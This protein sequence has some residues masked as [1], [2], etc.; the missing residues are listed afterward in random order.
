MKFVY[1][2]VVGAQ[3]VGGQLWRG[4]ALFT[5]TFSEAFIR[6]R[7]ASQLCPPGNHFVIQVITFSGR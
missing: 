5:E 3:T 7:T 6:N 4:P 1:C 2:S